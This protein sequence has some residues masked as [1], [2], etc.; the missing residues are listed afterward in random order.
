[1]LVACRRWAVAEALQIIA[2]CGILIVLSNIADTLRHIR[3]ELRRMNARG[4]TGA[5]GGQ[6]E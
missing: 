6:A 4:V 5:P 2:L 3:D 1:M